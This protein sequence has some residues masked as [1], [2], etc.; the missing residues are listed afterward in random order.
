MSEDL[1]GQDT[2]PTNDLS[3]RVN[4]IE[5]RVTDI[6]AFQKRREPWYRDTG[7]LISVA[8]FTISILTSG[9]TAYRTY[10][11][12]INARKDA[13]QSLI[14]Q[15][16]SSGIN[17]IALQ[18][19]IQK[20]FQTASNNSGSLNANLI[21]STSYNPALAGLA[22]NTSTTIQGSVYASNAMLAKKSLELVTALGDNASS[23]D[24]GEV[25]FILQSS[26][27]FEPA[28]KSYVSAIEKA[29]N[30]F[31]YL[32]AVR[33]LAQLEYIKGD[34]DKANLDLTQALD[35]FTKYSDEK[36]STDYISFTHFQTYMY[37]TNI[38]VS[39]CNMANKSLDQAIHY[40]SLMSP[41][42]L[43][44]SGAQVQIQNAKVNL[45]NCSK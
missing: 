26:S 40:S 13:L 3:K 4:I 23:L 34:K 16:Y 43:L 41:S 29:S 17:T 31:E 38:V 6:I 10:R 45:A 15:F 22:A 27:L 36:P 8:A 37:W 33:G 7:V 9:I 19:N 25:A 35:V 11:Q 2:G 20:D 30:S 5:D 44:S 42:L 32:G 12:D 39:D 24:H 18:Y 14:Q 28:R 1:S 21:Q